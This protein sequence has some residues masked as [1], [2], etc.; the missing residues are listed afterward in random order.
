MKQRVSEIPA[1][2]VVFNKPI[3]LTP[4]DISNLDTMSADDLRALCRRF[5]CQCGIAA[6]MTD[7]E[8]AQAMLDV[9]A[10]T[11]LRPIALGA[12]IKADMRSRMEAISS[13]LDRKKGKPKQQI[14]TTV[15]IGLF[16]I[17]EDR[18]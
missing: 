16:E 17:V 12:G 10:E 3:L 11:A 9:L 1:N 4:A 6:S 7:E 15:T 13:W 18:K 8:T 5:A 14:D 2:D